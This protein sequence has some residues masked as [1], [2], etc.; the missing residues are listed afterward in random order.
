MCK[1]CETKK[2][3]MDMTIS[4]INRVLKELNESLLNLKKADK[5]EEGR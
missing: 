1:K 4:K 2:L 5:R 3:K